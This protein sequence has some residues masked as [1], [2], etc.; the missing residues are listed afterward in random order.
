M[1]LPHICLRV[2][3]VQDTETSSEEIYSCRIVIN[4][5]ISLFLQND[6]LL[7]QIQPL[8]RFIS[9]KILII[10]L[11]YIVYQTVTKSRNF[12][13]FKTGLN[14]NDSADSLLMLNDVVSCCHVHN[15]SEDPALYISL[16]KYGTAH[17]TH[18]PLC[19]IINN[20][21]KTLKMNLQYK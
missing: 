21:Q 11:Q 9:T 15:R 2:K 19:Q 1:S 14:Q 4:D 8:I 12:R 3:A 5:T 13:R 10:S 18:F 17:K 20:L 6:T 16:L 7:I